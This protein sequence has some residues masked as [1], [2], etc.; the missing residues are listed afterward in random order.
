MGMAARGAGA[1]IGSHIGEALLPA[2]VAA[3]LHSRY[4][5]SKQAMAGG[6]GP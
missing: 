1:S 6:G 5:K 3:W 4:T 2:L